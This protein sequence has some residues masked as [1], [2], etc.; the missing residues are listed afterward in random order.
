[1]A[2][3]GDIIRVDGANDLAIRGFVISGPL[4]NNLFC[5]AE[6]R[7]GLF[8]AGEGSVTVDGNRFQEIRATDPSLRGCQNGIAIRVGR[9]AAP[10]H[11]GTATITSNE[12][13]TY[14]KGAIVVDGAESSADVGLNTVTG[15]GPVPHI[16]QNGIQFSRGATGNAAG[17][18]VSGHVY[19]PKPLAAGVLIFQAGSGLVIN[20]NN[21]HHN[22]DNIDLITTDGAVVQRNVAQDSNYGLF[23]DSD[24]SGNQ[25]VENFADG[26][27]SFD[28]QDLSIAVDVPPVANTWT[29]NVGTLQFP[30]GTCTPFGS[31]EEQGPQAR[32]GAAG[33]RVLPAG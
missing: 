2:E 9:Q 26:N 23:A 32:A 12:F 17:N 8:V 24:T 27:E 31:A 13:V 25:F 18:T 10:S 28:C 1:M 7:A 29:D 30:P 19:A 20:N 22:D 15:D 21:V 33:H 5:S 11:V 16:A 3:P 4:P 6:T 14:Q